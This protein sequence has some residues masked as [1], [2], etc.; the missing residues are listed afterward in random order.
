MDKE[1]IKKVSKVKDLQISEY[2]YF[3]L[4]CNFTDRQKEIYE[5]LNRGLN[6]V[7]ISEFQSSNFKYLPT[8]ESTVKREKKKIE[9]KII[10]VIVG[11][12]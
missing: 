8:S 4:N 5:L 7:E 9:E 11:K 10:S 6:I 2:E 1:R 3:L 12:L